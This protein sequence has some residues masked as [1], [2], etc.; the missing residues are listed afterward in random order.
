MNIPSQCRVC[1]CVQWIPVTEAKVARP[2]P[3]CHAI[4]HARQ[5]EATDRTLALSVAAAVMLV[6]ANL[7][8]VM[9]IQILGRSEPNTILSGVITL[10][11][12]GLWPLAA[13]VFIASFVVPLFKLISLWILLRA[14]RG[15]WPD[16]RRGLTKLYRIIRFIGRW[17]MLDVF[18]V[19]FLTG[20][21]QL[22]PLVA[23]PAGAGIF[24][25][26]TSV[27]LTVLATLTFDPRLMWDHEHP[28][29]Y[30]PP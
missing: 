9:D 2:C 10:W 18:L 24:S 12:S 3:R 15:H 26:G 14:A 4:V 29:P 5:P 17:S 1:E 19:A 6:P 25:F 28:S 22:H 8:P 21:V 7:L 16:H 23:I 11:T 27:V 13:I 20:L 30:S